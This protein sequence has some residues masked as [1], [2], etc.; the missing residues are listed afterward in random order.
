[1]PHILIVDDDAN[2]AS[3]LASL[4]DTS[5][6]SSVTVGSLR[7][8]RQHLMLMPVRAIFLDLKLPDGN[9]FELCDDPQLIG[10]A[11]IVL[12]TGHASIESSVQA[13]RLG[14][15]DYLTK[16]LRIDQ[17]KRVLERL[18]TSLTRRT[19]M[20]ALRSTVDCANGF[21]GLIGLS[22]PM[23]RVYDQIARV[24]PTAVNVLLVGESGTGKEVVAQTIHELSS[25]RD[26][27]FLA[28]NCGAISPQLIES[29]LFGHEKGSFTGATRQ[30][31]GYFERAHT[32][33]LFLDEVTEM[34]LDLQVKL[35]RVL[36]TGVFVRVGSEEPIQTDIRI[37]AATNRDPMQAV[38]QGRLREDLYYRLDVF[39]IQLPPLRDR[40]DDIDLLACAF[41]ES[42]NRIDGVSRSLSPAALDSLKRYR[43]PGNVRELRNVVHRAA[44]M[45]D[46]ACIDLVE[47]PC[48]AAR[49]GESETASR[50]Q[51]EAIEVPIG[52]SI[53]DA[54][55]QLILATMQRC[56]GA[57]ERAAETLGIS[58]KTLYNRLR[59][60]EQAAPEFG[61]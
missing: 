4:L 8:A 26:R 2:S 59:E 6:F 12:I 7:E 36:E 16:P 32:G 45:S 14:A 27:P 17:L 9:G 54:E 30:H 18:S 47:L 15:V 46:T 43:W 10:Q 60:Y 31:R 1:M 33:T 61:R 23:R 42:L 3:M 57:R 19:E 51:H 29:E 11:D 13:L 52:T 24:A 5:G 50:S 38:Q 28:I 21:A 55:R 25:R 39:R 41:L 53:A 58:L 48:S 49:R 22:L 40:T 20:S 34:P 44:I 56:G 35:L 37:I